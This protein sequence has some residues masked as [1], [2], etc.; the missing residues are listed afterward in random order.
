M[1]GVESQQ[2]LAPLFGLGLVGDHGHEELPRDR[3]DRG[4][5]VREDQD[6]VAVV[7]V[8]QVGQKIELCRRRHRQLALQAVGMERLSSF[9]RAMR[10][11][12]ELRP[13]I[14]LAHA[15]AGVLD[16]RAINLARLVVADAIFRAQVH[17]QSLD[18]IV[19]QIVAAKLGDLAAVDD[20]ADQ[21]VEVGVSVIG[22]FRRGGEPEPEGGDGAGRRQAVGRAGKVVA[23]VKD[24]EPESVAEPLHVQIG[25]VV[26]CHRDRL[27]VV[28]AAAQEPDLDV[29]AQAELVVP[30]VQEVDRR[31]DDQRGPAGFFDRHAGEVGLAGSGRQDDHSALAGIPPGLQGLDLVWERF[32][33]DLQP[34]FGRLVV[35]RGI[36]VAEF[37]VAQVLDDRAVKDRRRAILTGARVELHAR[38][39][40]IVFGFR[41]VD[42]ERARVEEQPNWRAL[43]VGGVAGRAHRRDS[44]E[45]A[46]LG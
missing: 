39:I 2:D 20:R 35:A 33:G 43:P 32:S 46:K 18:V 19:G 8:E 1:P 41:A 25:R 28:V 42:D 13:A 12:Q 44:P 37:F 34:P 3:V 14:G 36:G 45:D 40:W 22:A 16:E 27:D 21:L 15:D 7:P 38:Q 5:V 10:Q 17:I 23:F 24:D 6:A 9:G 30:L 31:C 26:G 11:E 29:E 4:V